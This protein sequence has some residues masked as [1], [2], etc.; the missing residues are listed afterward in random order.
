MKLLKTTILLVLFCSCKNTQEQQNNLDIWENIQ[1]EVE[2][3]NLNYLLKISN[4]TLSCLGCNNGKDWT[5]K[6]G[7][8]NNHIEQMR[9]VKNK[10]Y[11]YYVEEINS[12]GDFKKRYRINYEFK[13]YNLIYTL[14]ESENE[15]RFQGVFSIP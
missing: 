8:F 9:T 2:I 3:K 1:K 11:T 4:D 13:K 10:K 5:T 6:H 12:V 7:F 14:L 15:I